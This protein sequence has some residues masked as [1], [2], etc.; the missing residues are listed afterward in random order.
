MNEVLKNS[1]LHGRDGALAQQKKEP[2]VLPGRRGSIPT[3]VQGDY[4]CGNNDEENN[5]LIETSIA[6]RRRSKRLR[7]RKT[8]GA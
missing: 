3:Q 6:G 2:H 4:G 7:E 1:S 8:D 5:H